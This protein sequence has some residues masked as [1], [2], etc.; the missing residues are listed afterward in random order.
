MSLVPAATADFSLQFNLKL[1]LEWKCLFAV[2][3]L[4][5]LWFYC[6]RQKCKLLLFFHST[7][8]RGLPKGGKRV[9]RLVGNGK[10]EE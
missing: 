9:V 10:G 7:S 8:V 3:G 4:R 6:Q 5:G 1:G 2:W